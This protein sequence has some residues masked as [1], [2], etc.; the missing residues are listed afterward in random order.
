MKKK[1]KDQYKEH[2]N[3]V[4]ADGKTTKVCF[5]DIIDYVINEKWYENELE[6]KNNETQRTII[7]A[8][9][10]VME[11]IRSKK[12]VSKYYPYKK[13]CCKWMK[14][15]NVFLVTS[16]CFCKTWLGVTSSKL[17]LVRQ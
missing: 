5:K 8:A 11:D 7:T 16:F 14:H 17:H 9:K 1:L 15:L 12:Y 3:F 10:L 13:V 4:A 2:I 6:D